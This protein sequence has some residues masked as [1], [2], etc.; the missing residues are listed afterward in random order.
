MAGI[1][2]IENKLKYQHEETDK[3]ISVAFKDLSQLMALAKEMTTLSKTIAS[4]LKE[5]GCE[6]TTDETILFKSHLMELGIEQ[7]VDVN[8]GSKSSSTYYQNLAKEIS[9]VINPVMERKKQEQLT[10][11]EVYCCFNRARCMDLVSPDDIKEACKLLKDIPDAQLTLIQ[12]ESGLIVVQKQSCDNQE[13]LEKTFKLVTDAK[14]LTPLQ[15]AS[16]L[17]I[18]VQLA[19]QRLKEAE[20]AGKLCRDE[21]I[22]GLRFYP[23]KFLELIN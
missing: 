22:E 12:Y 4:R 20:I 6:V 7:Q 13:I 19:R 10:L 18:P 17:S 3:N 1:G 5:R 11:S 9:K 23:N 21:S 15:L 2:K 16:R 14:H 8:L